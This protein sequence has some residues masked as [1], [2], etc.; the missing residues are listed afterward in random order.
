MFSNH[1]NVPCCVYI[2]N[3]F[4]KIKNIFLNKKYFKKQI[5][6]PHMKQKCTPPHK[7]P[8]YSLNAPCLPSS[9]PL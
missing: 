4:L 2:K 1:F 8:I 5:S 6:N 9:E 3:N 7:S